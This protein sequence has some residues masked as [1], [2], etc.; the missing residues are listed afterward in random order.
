MER[1]SSRVFMRVY[2]RIHG[3]ND[4]PRYGRAASRGLSPHSRGKRR[5]AISLLVRLGSIPAFTG[6]TRRRVGIKP[7]YQVYPRIHGG[8]LWNKA[9]IRGRSGLSPHSRGKLK[10]MDEG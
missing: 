7:A 8:N 10:F 5:R 9:A 1:N 4:I 2:P 3:G 6:E